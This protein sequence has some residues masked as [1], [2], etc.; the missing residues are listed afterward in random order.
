[1]KKYMRNLSPIVVFA[2]NRLVHLKKTIN[3]LKKCNLSKHSKLIIYLDNSKNQNE[4]K[5]II[6]V[7]KYCLKIKGFKEIKLVEREKNLGM[8]KNIILGVGQ[9]LKKFKKGI[10][11]EDDMLLDKYFL[12]YMNY[13]LDL[14]KDNNKIASIHGYSYPTKKNLPSF[15]FLKGADCWG[16]GTW[17]RAWRLYNDDSKK[18]SSQLHSK[19]LIKKFNFNDS[20]DY[21]KMLRKNLI[22]KNNSWAIN[23]YASCFLKNKLTLYPGFSLVHNFGNDLSGTNCEETEVFNV[24]LKNKP[25]KFTHAKTLESEYAKKQFELFFLSIMTLKKRFIRYFSV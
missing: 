15:F 5:K 6:K 18:L 19:K 14:Y 17:S 3:S 24:E 7:K 25:L 21:F 20:Y 12:E 9:T 22:V 23:W 11:L 8:S 13:Y 10:F 2:Y 1:M 16:W 4:K